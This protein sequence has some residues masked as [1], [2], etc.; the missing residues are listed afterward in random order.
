MMEAIVF[1][2]PW[3]TL[4]PSLPRDTKTFWHWFLH[5]LSIVC[6]YTGLA[7][8]TVNKHNNNS[9][10]YTTWHGVFGIIVCCCITIQA[11]GGIIEMFPSLL[12]FKVSRVILKR[13]HAVSGTVTYIGAMVTVVLGLYSKWFTSNVTNIVVWS[14]LCCCPVVMLLIVLVQFIRNHFMLMIGRY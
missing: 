7:V 13:L 12:P 5:S 9:P 6:A 2:S 14:V 8:I 1:F 3:F 4:N 11:S 10:H